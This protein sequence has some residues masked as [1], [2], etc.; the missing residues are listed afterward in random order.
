MVY[1]HN[2]MG[3]D[4][5]IKQTNWNTF[6][7][8]FSPEYGI[9]DTINYFRGLYYTFSHVYQQL[10]GKD[11]RQTHT[12]FEIPIYI[13]QGRHDFNAP[14][15]LA[16]DCYEKID[17]PDKQ[18]IWFERSGHNPWINESEL[19]QEKVREGGII[20]C[21]AC[22]LSQ[23]VERNIYHRSEQTHRPDQRSQSGTNPRHQPNQPSDEPD[24]T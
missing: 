20:V 8:I 12:E 9:L 13:L 23:N 22:L 19:F 2:M 1:L 14:T 11:L 17:A 4:N 10:Y 24:G 6:K 18:L 3:R 7:I 15:Y 21:R 5:D 16:E